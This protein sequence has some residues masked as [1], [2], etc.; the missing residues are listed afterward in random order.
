MTTNRKLQIKKG[1]GGLGV[2]ATETI[3]KGK[4]ICR[5]GGILLWKYDA[6]QLETSQQKHLIATGEGTL[7]LDGHPK[8]LMCGKWICCGRMFPYGASIMSM[9]NASKERKSAN[10]IKKIGPGLFIDSNGRKH[11]EIKEIWLEAKRDI[12][13]GEQLLYKY[14]IVEESKFQKAECV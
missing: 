7:V 12:K 10:C 5:Y 6:D 14:R 3:P 1:I 9:V 8:K 13:N 4:R 11:K 2:Y